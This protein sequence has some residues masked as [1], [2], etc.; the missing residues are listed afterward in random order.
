MAEGRPKG[1]VEGK[2]KASPLEAGRGKYSPPTSPERIRGK[3][4]SGGQGC[5]AGIFGTKSEEGIMANGRENPLRYRG[6]T[7]FLVTISFIVDTVSGVILYVAPPGRIA[8]WTNWRYWGLDREEWVAIHTIFGYILLIVVALH[9]SYNWKTFTRFLWDKVRRALNLRWELVAATLISIGVFL[10]TLW[11]LPPFST[12]MSLGERVKNSWEESRVTPPVPHAE[13]MSLKELSTRI[14]VPLE[15]ILSALESKGYKVKNA[16]QT[17]GEIAEE[18]GISPNTLFEAMKSGGV[19]PALPETIEGTGLGKKT[20]E[21]ICTERGFS[22]DEVL[23]R[24]KKSGID[25]KP[26]DRVKDVAN[27]LGKKP[28]EIFR[29]ME[30]EE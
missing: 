18:N 7:T 11:N 27:K 19:R 23:S 12:T 15:R 24:L 3:R 20:L 1:A 17:L 8:H 26:T 14:Q 22:L 13:R 4:S 16:Q 9:L 28:I 6:M 25:A 21:M 2:G 29:I 30:G 5:F 10:G